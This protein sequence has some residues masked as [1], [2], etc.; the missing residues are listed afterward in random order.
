MN[1]TQ[2]R[3]LRT[4]ADR[5]PVARIIELHL[6]AP[7]RQSGSETGVAVFAALT[8]VHGTGEPPP[9]DAI[10]AAAST[11]AP[12]HASAAGLPLDAPSGDENPELP[13]AGAPPADHPDAD[14]P[15]GDEAP[16]RDT[17][18][19]VPP[20]PYAPP[21]DVPPAGDPPDDDPAIEPPPGHDAPVGDPP[22]REAPMGRASGS[23]DVD[24][25]PAEI[26][27]GATIDTLD[28][29]LG[30]PAE[31]LPLGEVLDAEVACDLS[32]LAG[33]GEP[34][35][36][37]PPLVRHVV[38]SARYRLVLKGIDRGKW[39]VDIVEEADAPL[40]TVD[41]VVR[42]VQRR[43]GD[44]ADVERFTSDTLQQALSET[45]WATTT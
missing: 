6:F 32:P 29:G 38:M 43:A 33:P 13:P 31:T 25:A 12:P 17:P 14:Q 2:Q 21:A 23:A 4:I 26:D 8:D 30:V 24:D 10:A 45:L 1:D 36:V 18:A 39:D 19:D 28:A 40:I 22:P 5:V 34:A 20:P 15:P 3:F 27:P 7:I 11:A 42:G 37:R 35:P 41:K 9:A 16:A 44:L